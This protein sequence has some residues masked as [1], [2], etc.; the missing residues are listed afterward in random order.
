MEDR[1]EPVLITDTGAGIAQSVQRIATDW[2]VRGSNA[3]GAKF[4]APVQTSSGAHPASYT[5][6]TGSYT[7]VKRPGRGVDHQPHLA[8][9]MK[10]EQSYTSAPP[11]GLR[12][13][14]QGELYPYHIFTL[15]HI[16]FFPPLSPLFYLPL[17]SCV[18]RTILMQEKDTGG[19]IPLPALSRQVTPLNRGLNYN[20]RI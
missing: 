17:F 11:L 12:V 5:M 10:E 16:H 15:L 4:S 1:F 2:T 19:G 9:R 6:S 14:F 7:V 3:G 20:T 13:L 18:A 8:P